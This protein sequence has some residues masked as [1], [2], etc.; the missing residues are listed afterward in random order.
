MANRQTPKNRVE[1]ELP[2]AGFER[3]PTVGYNSHL[4]ASRSARE[5]SYEN[6]I[7]W[8]LLVRNP[9][10]ADEQKVAIEKAWNLLFDA[11]IFD[12]RS[13]FAS[14]LL[15]GIRTP[16]LTADAAAIANCGRQWFRKLETEGRIILHRV[17]SRQTYIMS[18]DLRKIMEG[19]V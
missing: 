4:H 18:E 13:Q 12:S 14:A 2:E 17:A 3:A 16:I 11:E 10:I 6:T 7:T 9:E 19:R 15:I 1:R 5:K 8:D